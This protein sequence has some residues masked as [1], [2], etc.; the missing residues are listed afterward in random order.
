M[1]LS[2][3]FVSNLIS[4]L[5]LTAFAGTA[6]AAEAG[7]PLRA[8]M[9]TGGCC[10]DYTAQKNIIAEG[11]S[12]RANVEWTIVQEGGDS[13]KFK[14]STY[15]QP[16]WAKGY[17]VVVHNECFADE[18]DVAWL[19][20]IVKPHHDG[21]PAVVI[22]CAMHCYRAP[23][24]EWF[25][26]VGVTSRGHGSH[27]EHD[28]KTLQAGHPIMAGFPATW[29]TPME[30][31]YNIEKVWPT[32]TPLA[33]SFSKETKKDETDVWINTYGKGRVFGTTIGHYN[34]TMQDPVFLDL[35]TRGLLW[36]CDQ[37]DDQGQPKP[38]YGPKKSN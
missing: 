14:V 2:T 24:D 35:V 26:F 15:A 18:K 8:L 38:G 3:S 30:E 32:A 23:S 11:V 1:K 10:H 16:D 9:I 21:V 27:F 20:Q 7:K 36:A 37:L 29:H 12:Q 19:D 25:K 22:H 34:K 17:D 31:L 33:S 4:T 5:A 28:V 13:T 6:L